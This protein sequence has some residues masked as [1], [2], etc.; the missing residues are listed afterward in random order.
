MDIKGTITKKGYT[1]KEVAERL[2]INRVTLSRNLSGTPSL[3]TL[4]K[5]AG[6]I[7]CNVG[8][9]FADEIETKET[10]GF[11]CPHC[12]KRIKVSADE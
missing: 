10:N 6:V 5:V 3:T 4:R 1:I 9:F 7:G 8:E 12:G 2:N 11:I